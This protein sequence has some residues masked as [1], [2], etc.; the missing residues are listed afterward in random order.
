MRWLSRHAAAPQPQPTPA[1][2]D[3]ADEIARREA[4][5]L[6]KTADALGEIHPDDQ[7]YW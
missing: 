5:A 4:D 6:R 7:K 3:P 2:D 1:P